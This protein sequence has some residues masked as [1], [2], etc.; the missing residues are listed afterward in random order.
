MLK[1]EN[2]SK[3]YKHEVLNGVSFSAK[4]GEIVGIA[5]ENGSGKS[6]L[7]S[8]MTGAAR[9]E[10]GRVLVEGE[11]IAKNPRALR[12]WVGYVPQEDS[13]FGNLSARDNLKLWAAAYGADWKNALPY[14]F[15]EPNGETEIFLRK[16]ADALSG[17]MRKRL[18]IALSLTHSPRYLIMDEPTA[19]LDIGF[20]WELM[21]TVREMSARGHCVIFTSHQP[22]ELLQCDRLYVLRGGAFV[23]AGDP[24][25]LCGGEPGFGEALFTL[26][27]ARDAAE[28]LAV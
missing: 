24:K 19:G 27:K 3:K 2:I 25:A 4:G 6:T 18:S 8:V 15:P 21:K 16:K 11:D 1:A 14:L 23:Y 5:G 17:G 28:R 13:L 9:P 12:K 7:L 20:K 22:D 10:A 26:I